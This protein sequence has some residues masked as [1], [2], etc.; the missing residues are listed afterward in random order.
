MLRHE[1]LEKLLALGHDVT[2]AMISNAYRYGGLDP[3]P[4]DGFGKYCWTDKDVML[5]SHYFRHHPNCRRVLD[6]ADKRRKE[7]RIVR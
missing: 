2:H 5:L 6:P 4:K 3:P 1:I 7:N